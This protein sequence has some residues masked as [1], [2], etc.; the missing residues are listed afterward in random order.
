MYV[1]LCWLHSY[2][3][4]QKVLCELLRTLYTQSQ[5]PKVTILFKTQFC[6]Q[7]C[8]VCPF[9]FVWQLPRSTQ[10]APNF[11]FP[12]LPPIPLTP[13]MCTYKEEVLSGFSKD[14]IFT[15]GNCWVYLL[16][17][18][19]LCKCSDFCIN[20]LFPNYLNL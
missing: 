6:Q 19:L 5:I 9:F 11:H 13:K 4:S 10:T 14:D 15:R 7:L 18:D 8:T 20:S 12:G 1:S 16:Q 17:S 3:Q 2:T